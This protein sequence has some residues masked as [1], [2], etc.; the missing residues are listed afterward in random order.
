MALNRY[1]FYKIQGNQ[2][3]K[4][5]VEL[6]RFKNDFKD[7]YIVEIF[8]YEF[9]VYAVKFYLKNHRDSKNRYNICYKKEFKMRFGFQT[10]NANFIKVLN[11]ILSIIVE[12]SKKDRLASFGF[13]GAPKESEANPEINSANINPDC[14]V[15]NTKRY[16][17]YHLYTRKYFNP[18]DFEYIDSSTSSIL[19]L[20]NNKNKEALTKE[21]AE[22]YILDTIIPS[23]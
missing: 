14:T 6:Y 16:K 13:M 12:I 22:N 21:V 1:D 20:R 8:H 19:L 5:K 9:N 2:R 23:L 11:T 18:T 3:N 17:V 7:I 4:E 10:G 15:A